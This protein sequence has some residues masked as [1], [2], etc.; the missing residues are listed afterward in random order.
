MATFDKNSKSDETNEFRNFDHREKNH[1]AGAE[2]VWARMQE[3]PKLPYSEKYGGFRV[4]TKYADAMSVGQ[5]W[6]VF[7]SEVAGISLPDLSFATRHIPVEIDPPKHKEYRDLISGILSRANVAKMEPT[8][9]EIVCNLVADIGDRTRVDLT[10][11]LARPLPVRVTLVLLGLPWKDSA[12][13]DSL[14]A[15]IHLH[16]GNESAMAVAK[17]LDQYVS[18]ILSERREAGVTDPEAD[19]VSAVLTGT[20]EGRHL[21]HEEQVS[22]IRIL[23][24]GGF[25]TTAI[26]LTTAMWWLAQHPEDVQRLRDDPNLW[27][28]A[29]D[30]F[31]RFSSPGAYLARTVTQE[32]EIGG[33][34]MKP[35]EKILISWA[36]ANR[37]PR[38]F[39]KAEEVVLDRA[40]NHHVGF[41]AGVHSCVGLHVAKLEMRIALQEMLK[42]YKSFRVDPSGEIRWESSENQGMVALPLILEPCAPN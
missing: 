13:L 17:Q 24:I 3:Q 12:K 28:S 33:C 19:L 41:G 4:V 25:E 6:R 16:R 27:T 7:S 35:G 18:D 37:D 15:Q 36:A 8:F 30:E 21:T 38:K 22:M 26:A 14:V 39:K 5:N 29:V 9:R 11:V 20:V 40:P 1:R 31:V 42:R 32:V 23:I 34:P 2:C 10:E